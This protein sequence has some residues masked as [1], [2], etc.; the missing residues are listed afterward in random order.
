MGNSGAKISDGQRIN[1]YK[2]VKLSV[3]RQQFKRLP[4][5]ERKHKLPWEP[6][7][8]HAISRNFTATRDK[9]GYLIIRSRNYELD[10]EKSDGRMLLCELLDT[11]LG[12]HELYF[13]LSAYWI[14]LSKAQYDCLYPEFIPA[15]VSHHS[16]SAHSASPYSHSVLPS[17]PPSVPHS[18][19]Y[20]TLPPAVPGIVLP[21]PDLP[22]ASTVASL[23]DSE[24]PPPYLSIFPD[25]SDEFESSSSSK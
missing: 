14:G 19:S 21:P 25:A 12:E 17:A 4:L 23:S 1:V 6:F 18:F 11:E 5:D 8:G 16:I 24:L 9:R 10:G 7:F 22:P 13:P 15:P 2:R 3:A 20:Y